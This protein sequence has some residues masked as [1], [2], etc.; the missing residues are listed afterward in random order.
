MIT[1][2]QSLYCCN[3]KP[4]IL[5]TFSVSYLFDT[6]FFKS[7]RITHPT[8]EP[9]ASDMRYNS[10]WPTV[11]NTK[12]PPCG[13]INV[14]L[15]AMDNAPATAEPMIQDGSTRNGSDAANGIA[16]SAIKESPIT[17]FVGP[18]FLSSS[19]NLFLKNMDASAIASGGSIPPTITAA[20][21]L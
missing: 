16:P 8:T 18:A 4:A 2:S 19:V 1:Y 13:A 6:S 10:G 17:M 14:Q 7:P 21:I 20:M 15:N 11:K 9:T 5:I 12:I 3:I